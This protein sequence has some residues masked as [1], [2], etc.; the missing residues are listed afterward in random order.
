MHGFDRDRDGNPLADI[1]EID[2]DG[3]KY[4]S[5]VIHFPAG[6]QG[7]GGMAA[8]GPGIDEVIP[9]V[10]RNIH[11]NVNGFTRIG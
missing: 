2:L 11:L 5:N 3:I 1:L 4:A 8:S 7:P 10:V 6:T 9:A